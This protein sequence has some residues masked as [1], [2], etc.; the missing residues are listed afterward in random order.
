MPRRITSRCMFT[1]SSSVSLAGPHLHQSPVSVPS[2]RHPHCRHRAWHSAALRWYQPMTGKWETGLDEKQLHETPRSQRQQN[3]EV[4]GVDTSK[5]SRPLPTPRFCT[6]VWPGS[7]QAI[8]GPHFHPRTPSPGQCSQLP[9]P[10]WVWPPRTPKLWAPLPSRLLC[11]CRIASCRHLV[12]TLTAAHERPSALGC[13]QLRG[14]QQISGGKGGP[15]VEN[16]WSQ[17]PVHS[18]AGCSSGRGCPKEARKCLSG[19]EDETGDSSADGSPSLS[20]QKQILSSR[21]YEEGAAPTV[22]TGTS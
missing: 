12:L 16:A 20:E 19:T 22:I 18:A 21:K 7:K 17:P 5:L 1:S 6:R 9:E 11:L 2:P 15:C 14:S 4:L 8:P 13:I 10:A 3:V